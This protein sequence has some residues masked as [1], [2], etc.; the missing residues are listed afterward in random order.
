LLTSTTR[1]IANPQAAQDP[2]KREKMNDLIL[3]LKGAM[4]AESKV[5]LMMNVKRT[6]LDRVIRQLPALKNPT[7]SPLADPDWVAVNTIIDEDTVRH[8]IPQLKAAGASGIV[9]YPISKIIE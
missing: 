9:E 1:F 3:M 2:W 4:A 5:G 7:I 8:I 6:D